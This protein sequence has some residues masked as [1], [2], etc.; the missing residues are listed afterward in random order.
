VTLEIVFLEGANLPPENIM[1]K[2]NKE[3]RSTIDM[4][5]IDF[6]MA[7]SI[8]HIIP[9]DFVI[10]MGEGRYPFQEVDY[11]RPQ[12]VTTIFFLQHISDWI[13]SP[14][15]TF[16][17]FMLKRKRKAAGELHDQEQLRSYKR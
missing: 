3:D 9:T 14:A 2:V 7:I 12:L 16:G 6:E 5:I 4:K 11:E 15:E 10:Q 17:S 13:Q 8:G 1:W